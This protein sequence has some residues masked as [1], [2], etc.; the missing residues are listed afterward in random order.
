LREVARGVAARKAAGVDGWRFAHLHTLPLE[1][2]GSLASFYALVERAGRWPSALGRNAVALLPKAG[3]RSVEDRRPAV[4]LSSVY[5]LWAA[6]RSRLLRAW[7]RANGVLAA[8]PAAAADFKAGLRAF[9]V[10]EAHL[11]GRP[12]SGLA[13][14]LSS[15][16][17]R[18]AV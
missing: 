16:S 17:L 2:F 1:W 6:S 8:G 4:L 3:S 15:E 11:E 18:K 7:L 10:A 12:V 14:G 5:R 13:V 9:A